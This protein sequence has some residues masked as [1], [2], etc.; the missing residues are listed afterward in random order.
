MDGD[1][2]GV[3][4]CPCVDDRVTD[5]RRVYVD[6]T[7]KRVDI[8]VKFIFKEILL[9]RVDVMNIVLRLAV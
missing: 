1:V 7:I 5:I 9:R 2:T 4:R 8:Q 3:K 6:K